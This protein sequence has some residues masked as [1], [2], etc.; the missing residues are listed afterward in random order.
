MNGF[1]ITCYFPKRNS[2]DCGRISRFLAIYEM[3]KVGF[4]STSFLYVLTLAA[5]SYSKRFLSRFFC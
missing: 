4:G 2:I 3:N 1:I 5:Q